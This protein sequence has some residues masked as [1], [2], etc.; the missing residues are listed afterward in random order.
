MKFLKPFIFFLAL[1]I[2]CISQDKVSLTLSQ[3]DS[4]F[5]K[6]NLL[7]L[8]QAYNVSA[9][10]ALILQAKSYPNPLFTADINALDPENQKVFHAGQSGQKAFA[11][12]QLILLGGKRKTE[13]ELARQNKQVAE[14]ELEDLLRNLRYQLHT[15]YYTINGQINTLG[16]YA[17][18]LELLDTLINSFEIQ[19]K[20]GN[21]PAKDVIR[22]K[23]VYFKINND[24]SLLAGDY[25]NE[26][27]K[28]QLL[29]QVNNY[30]IPKIDKSELDRLTALK[31]YDELLAT[32]LDQRPD[33]K[34][35]YQQEAIALLNLKYQKKLAI[36]DV[37]VN[38]SYDQRGG[39]FHNQMNVGVNI[40]LPL[41]NRNRGNIKA[42]EYGTNTADLY[43]QQKTREVQTDVFAA[44][45][46]LKLS[47]VEYNK[48]KSYYT[49]DFD[50]VFQGV[51][52]N[53][54]KRN[55]SIL[56]FVDFFEAYNE[57]LDE[58]ERVKTNLANSAMKINLATAS[59][60]Y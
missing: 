19:S 34:E 41:W 25:F 18:Q 7:L 10:E 29:L 49:E 24:K 2:I 17:R 40:P 53:F 14:L 59:K 9:Q 39:A 50:V 20:R 23:S 58:Y 11:I 47:I 32:A 15:S 54:Q 3:V 13:I 42:A 33:L 27:Q 48:I 21:I 4:L 12:E 38:T 8:A 5:L 43:Q 51:N 57:S 16:K 56:E 1:P 31:E 26:Q 28:I 35:A 30:L 45:Q 6:N 60:I 46:T 55:I 36:P 44:W 52:T 37:A 22:L